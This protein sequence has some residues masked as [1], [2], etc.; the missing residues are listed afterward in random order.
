MSTGS[1]NAKVIAP[2]PPDKEEVKLMMGKICP[3]DGFRPMVQPAGN[4]ND[5]L[6]PP[7]EL[8]SQND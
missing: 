7:R 3:P 2:I 5:K 8:E 4:A 6:P 1:G